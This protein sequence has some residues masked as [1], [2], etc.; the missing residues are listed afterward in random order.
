M[1]EMWRLTF[2]APDEPARVKLYST[3]EGAITA[4]QAMTHSYD[5]ICLECV[6]RFNPWSA[7]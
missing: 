3:R 1:N 5:L 7:R 6:A 2:N 4:A